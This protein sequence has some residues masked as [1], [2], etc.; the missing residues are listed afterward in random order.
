MANRSQRPLSS[1]VASVRRPSNRG[2]RRTVASPPAGCG[3]NGSL[4]ANGAGSGSTG[5]VGRPACE[6]RA[7]VVAHRR[8]GRHLAGSGRYVG[9]SVSTDANRPDA[10]EPIGAQ[11]HRVAHRG[12]GDCVAG[13]RSEFHRL[14]RVRLLGQRDS[15]C[16]SANFAGGGGCN[17]GWR[18][19]I[20][21]ASAHCH[22][23]AGGW[24]SR[25]SFGAGAN[26]SPI[27]QRPQ[28]HDS[29]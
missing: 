25:L 9:G 5:L 16:G 14:R 29:G 27:C 6:N 10:A 8:G 3:Q 18:H 17:A 7:A 13:A 2:V 1:A 21:V 24:D 4:G 11:Q 23:V 20:V 15:P 22:P 28:R 12:A 26:L 19:G